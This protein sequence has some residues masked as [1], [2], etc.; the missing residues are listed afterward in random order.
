MPL[1]KEWI[2]LGGNLMTM[3]TNDY[4]IK[5]NQLHFSLINALKTPINIATEIG[6][7][8]INVKAEIGQ[9]NFLPW[10]EGNCDFSEDTAKRYMKLFEY[11]CKIRT[12]RNLQEAYKKI[13]TLEKQKRQTEKQHKDSLINERIKTGKIPDKWERSCDYEYQ[14]RFKENQD[15]T[16]R[17]DIA[18]EKMNN[19]K[20]ERKQEQINND[21][22]IKN[23]EDFMESERGKMQFREKHLSKVS[24][25][26]SFYDVIDDY[27][28]TLDNGN[29]QIEALNGIIKYCRDKANILHRSI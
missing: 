5:I 2:L 4:K 1:K 15:R 28:G 18:K 29:R 10:I 23:A 27:V 3:Q 13:E 16:N 20:N 26:N 6:E 25:L 12:V 9:G 19:V 14:K 11:N 7:L 22:I 17:I 8:L 21:A 24:D